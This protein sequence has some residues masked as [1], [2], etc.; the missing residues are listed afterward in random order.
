MAF[1]LKQL[2]QEMI[3]ES[4]RSVEM[5]KEPHEIITIL[6]TVK[7]DNRQIWDTLKTRE[8]NEAPCLP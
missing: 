7:Q 2:S 8:S 4:G 6:Q 1:F 5:L 3:I